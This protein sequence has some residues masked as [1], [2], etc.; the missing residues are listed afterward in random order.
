LLRG[1][2]VL[3]D[4]TGLGVSLMGFAN[5][6]TARG[7]YELI[8]ILWCAAE[9]ASYVTDDAFER[10]AGE[11]VDGIRDA[12]AL[13]GIYLELHG[14]MVTQSFED[15]EGELLR[16]IRDVT[17]P[18][19]PLVVSFDLHA[20]VTPEIF[21]HASAITI[22]RTYPHVDLVE[23]GAR[24]FRSLERLLTPGPIYKAFRQAPFLVPL[25]SQHTGSEPCQAIYAG[26]GKLHGETVFSADIA[27]G[28]PPADIFHAGPSVVAYAGSQEIA[29]RAAD[30]LLQ[31]LVDAEE[32]FEDPLLSPDA[33]VAEA[34]AH[35]GPKPVVIA[36]AQDNPGAG[37]PS[38]TTG[39]LSALVR[40]NAQGVI[41]AI[42]NDPDV[43]ARAHDMGVG[44]EFSTLLGG[45]SGLVNQ[46]PIAG[47]FRVETL[48]NGRFPFSGAMYDGMTASL[49]PMAVLRILDTPADIRVVIGSVRCQCLDQAI[50]THL[51]IEPARQR[52]VV[53][54]SSVHFRADFESIA[55]KV[56]VVE[57]PGSHPC[58]LDN[59]TY[60]NLRTGVR[61]GPGG[62]PHESSAHNQTG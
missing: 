13:D 55:E 12:A 29:D 30:A 6:A 53:V 42:L 5:S 45:K 39:V 51:G 40:G 25:T 14:A 58:R 56:L 35:K 44:A 21:R 18:H 60:R 7:G 32:R 1:D 47:C 52:I 59:I 16:R 23:T 19:L 31:S 2:D 41:L 43:A 27:M 9:P 33:A 50:F 38:D 49:G 57:A 15:G 46:D 8:P 61:L 24:A 54:K 20:N 11:M 4:L 26:L 28:F 3:R 22:L 37:A 62:R 36:D 17:G 34:M 48:S 10:I